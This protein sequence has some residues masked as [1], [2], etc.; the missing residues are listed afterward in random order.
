MGSRSSSALGTKDIR[1]HHELM[2]GLVVGA[3]LYRGTSGLAGGIEGLC[4]A[5]QP[6]L[7]L[8][9]V[10]LQLEYCLAIEGIPQL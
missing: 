4:L 7:L 10:V 8:L 6:T 1:P 5:L 9:A 3:D 2:Y